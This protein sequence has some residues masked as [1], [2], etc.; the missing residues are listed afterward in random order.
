METIDQISPLT[1]VGNERVAARVDYCVCD[2]CG[3]RLKR[4]ETTI[5]NDHHLTVEHC[6]ICEQAGNEALQANI[7]LSSDDR[8]RYFDFWLATHGLDRKA[9]ACHYHLQADDFFD[10]VSND[11]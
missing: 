6:P 4:V 2:R 1:F 10:E 8:L 11:H 3:F 5:I 9:L 7:T